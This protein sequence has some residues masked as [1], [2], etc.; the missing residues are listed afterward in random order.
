[1]GL[2]KIEQEVVISFNAEEGEADLYTANP[3]WIRKMDKLVASKPELFRQIREDYYKGK[4]VSK[5]YVF[6]KR[7]VSIRTKETKLNLTDEQRQK[8]AEQ[9]R[10]NLHG[11]K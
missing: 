3:A 8:K 6:P 10:R 11:D 4:V 7:L 2:L 9:A 5:R 1:M